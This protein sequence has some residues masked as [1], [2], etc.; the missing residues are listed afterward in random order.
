[1]IKPLYRGKKVIF[2]ICIEA[3]TRSNIKASAVQFIMSKPGQILKPENESA[4]SVTVPL[5]M[6][7]TI[8]LSV[9]H[10]VIKEKI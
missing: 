8:F 5:V 4:T 1:M 3:K 7:I 6:S 9:T 10:S 2:T